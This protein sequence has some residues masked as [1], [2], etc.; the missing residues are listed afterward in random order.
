M[1]TQSFDRLCKTQEVAKAKE[2]LAAWTK[3][4]EQDGLNESEIRFLEGSIAK[5]KEWIVRAER[6]VG[7]WWA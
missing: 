5:S 1:S 7:E 2:A 3:A 4:L 6:S